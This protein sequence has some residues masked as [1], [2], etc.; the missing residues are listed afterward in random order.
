M[1]FASETDAEAN[2]KAVSG[3][4]LVV[5]GVKPW[6][7]VEAA[8]EIADALEPGAIVVSVAAGVS[9]EAIEAVLPEGAQVVR[10]MPNTPSHVGRGVTGVAGGATASD[11]AVEIVRRLFLAVGEALV[12]REDQINAIAAVSGSGP[13]YLFLYAEQM[14]AAAERL[15]FTRDQAETLAIGTVTGA[16]ELLRQSGEDPAQLRRNVTSPNGT[17]EKAIEVLQAANL[18]DVYDRAFAANIRRSEELSG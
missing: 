15:G 2:R 17:T 4:G 7:I 6:N 11:E 18:G 14:T 10:A 12:V 13:A 16:A 1:A 9:C 3:A 5:L 8:T